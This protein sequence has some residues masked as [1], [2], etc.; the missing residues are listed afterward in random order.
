MTP[1]MKKCEAQALKLSPEERALLA[2]HL[3]AS[4]NAQEDKEN[5]QVW[6][7]EANGRYQEY[8]QGNM[9]ARVAEDVLRDARVVPEPLHGYR[10]PQ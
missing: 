3:L 5:E 1:D 2:E 10:A 9:T 6:L 8:K 4:L 7:Q